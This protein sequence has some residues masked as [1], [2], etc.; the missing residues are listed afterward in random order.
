MK[1]LMAVRFQKKVASQQ[2][3]II[4]AARSISRDMTGRYPIM[5]DQ[6]NRKIKT[7]SQ[8]SPWIES[9]YHG[10]IHSKNTDGSSVSEKNCITE[11]DD[12]LR[13]KIDFS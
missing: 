13:C 8:H 3:M 9:E 1:A 11:N 2:M 12:P 10:D 4:S 7:K 6:T 5:V